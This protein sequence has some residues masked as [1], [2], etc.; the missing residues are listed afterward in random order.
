MLD[1]G[2]R[3]SSFNSWSYCKVC[4]D[5]SLWLVWAG[6]AGKAGG[7]NL[8]AGVLSFKNLFL[9]RIWPEVSNFISDA[10]NLLLAVERELDCDNKLADEFC[11]DLDLSDA[12]IAGVTNSWAFLLFLS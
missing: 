5:S 1:I 12:A 8:G 3:Q 7:V 11:L 6:L 9:L 4:V 10:N 2:E